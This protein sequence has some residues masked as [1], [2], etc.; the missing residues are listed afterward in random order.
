MAKKGSRTKKNVDGL[1]KSR[2]YKLRE[3]HRDCCGQKIKTYLNDEYGIELS[4]K[5]IYKI[6]GEKY[7]LRSEWKKN[8]V[9]GAVPEAYRPRKVIQMDSV[10]FGAVFAFTAVDIFSK[11]VAVRLYPALTSFEDAHFL[12]ASMKGRFH[13]TQLL[14]TDGGPE[15]KDQFKRIVFRYT[16]RFRISRPYRKNEQS[17]I[18]SFNRSLRKECL[19]WGKFTPGDLPNLK[20]EVDE[21]LDYYHTKRVHLSL[22]MRTPN[23]SLKEHQV[24][25]I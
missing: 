8:R 12:R 21:Y 6:L 18:E 24:S 9:R 20:R 19:G 22:D 4:L 13:Y 2:I 25:D 7:K 17:Y 11:E 14:Q 16:N 23:D 1:L 10:D 5:T 15:F 3:E